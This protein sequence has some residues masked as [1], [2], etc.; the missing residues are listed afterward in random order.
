MRL[1]PKEEVNKVMNM[2]GRARGRELAIAMEGVEEG[3]E[4]SE[5]VNMDGNELVN[6]VEEGDEVEVFGDRSIR[7]VHCPRKLYR[8]RCLHFFSFSHRITLLFNFMQLYIQN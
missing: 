3:I 1:N 6:V 8:K 2:D 4:R 5:T 7:A